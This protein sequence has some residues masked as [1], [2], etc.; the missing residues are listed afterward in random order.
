MR[1]FRGAHGDTHGSD[2]HD[3][4]HKAFMVGHAVPVW[5]PVVQRIDWQDARL[6]QGGGDRDARTDAGDQVKKS[7]HVTVPGYPPFPMILQEDA[8]HATA[9]AVARLVWPTCTVE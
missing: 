7:W 1:P 6:R 8:D 2:E 4:N 3:D 5:R 9:L